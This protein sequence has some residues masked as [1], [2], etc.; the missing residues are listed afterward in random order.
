MIQKIILSC[1]LICLISTKTF[2]Q[3]VGIGTATPTQKLE[4]KGNTQVDSAF[5]MYPAITTIPG[6]AITVGT[7]TSSLIITNSGLITNANL[8]SYT[9]TAYEGQVLFINN[10]DLSDATFANTRI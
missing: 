1:L 8:I 4:V 6:A 9:A 5:M 3:F 10:N 7:P 2:A